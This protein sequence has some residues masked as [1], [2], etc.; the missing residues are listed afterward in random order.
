MKTVKIVISS[1]PTHTKQLLEVIGKNGGGA[2]GEYTYCSFTTEGIGRFKPSDNANPYIGTAGVFEE[3]KED[4][5]EFICTRDKAKKIIQ[6]IKQAH[7][8]EEVALDIYPLLD[9]NEL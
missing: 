5:I 4:K 3:V 8:Y 1:P 7:P 9:E 6:A 2:L